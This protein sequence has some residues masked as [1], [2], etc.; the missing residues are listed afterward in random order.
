MVVATGLDS[1]TLQE[2]DIK[3]WEMWTRNFKNKYQI[4][5]VI[6]TRDHHLAQWIPYPVNLF[7]PHYQ[8]VSHGQQVS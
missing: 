8:L 7:L 4:K 6:C 5:S 3:N 2:E 1:K